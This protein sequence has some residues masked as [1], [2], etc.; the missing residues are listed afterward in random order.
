VS[1]TLDAMT[2]APSPAPPQGP[3]VVPPFPAPPTE[4]RRLRI[5]LGLGI[6]ALVLLLV[7]GGG[8]AALV[9]LSTVTSRALNEQADVVIGAYIDDVRA[10]RYAEAYES[11]CSETRATTTQA[12]FTSQVADDEPIRDYDVGDLPFTSV[13]LAVPVTVTYENGD[14]DV[15]RAYLGQNQQTGQFQVCRLQE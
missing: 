10:K 4:G 1:T 6:G 13:D 11:L 2:A 7:C 12:Q 5:G 8:V 9:G 15:L 3:G 14:T